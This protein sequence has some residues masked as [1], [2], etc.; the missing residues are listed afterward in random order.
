MTIEAVALS[1]LILDFSWYPRAKVDDYNVNRLVEALRAGAE[2]PPPIAERGS[3][4]VS[5]GFHRIT[6]HRKVHPDDVIDV[7]VVEYEDEAAFMLDAGRR[8]SMHGVGLTS[9][10]KTR[11]LLRLRELGVSPEESA[12]ALQITVE[13][14]DHILTTKTAQ[15]PEGQTVALRRG[16]ASLARTTMTPQQVASAQRASGQ[17][18]RY[19]I[20]V[21]TNAVTGDLVP[22]EDG[23]LMRRLAE[24]GHLLVASYGDAVVPV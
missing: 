22:P 23:E 21:V 10:D 20:G 7:D 19:H 15:T 6:A 17:A 11:L 5:D 4:R 13:K 16:A 2:L 1:D 12:A 18:L 8:N 14:A 3:M 24:L 9:Y